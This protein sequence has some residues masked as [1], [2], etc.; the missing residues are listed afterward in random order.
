MGATNICNFVLHG[1]II[2]SLHCLYIKMFLKKKS[3]G[4]RIQITVE[5]Y[6]LESECNGK[7]TVEGGERRKVNRE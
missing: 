7:T 5:I 6:G 2:L 4:K 3:T 1:Y